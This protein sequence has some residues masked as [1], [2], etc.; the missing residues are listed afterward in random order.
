MN[1]D[2]NIEVKDWVNIKNQGD[3]LK[4][5]ITDTNQG[6]FITS[7]QKT[8]VVEDYASDYTWRELFFKLCFE[9]MLQYF[10][11]HGD[12]KLFYKYIDVMGPYIQTL[13]IKLLDKKKFK[14]NNYYLMVLTGRMKNLKIVKFHKDSLVTLGVDGFKYLQKG[15]KYFSEN[16]G[17]L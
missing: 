17:S 15:F 3:R 10:P 9:Q 13:R 12:F 4:K 11:E 14:S 7:I 8:T 6:K 16:D 2:D 1:D 5:Y